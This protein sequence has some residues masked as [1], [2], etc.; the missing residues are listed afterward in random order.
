VLQGEFAEQFGV[1]EGTAFISG[2]A[3]GKPEGILTNSD[4]SSVSSTSNDV[5]H[6]DDFAKLLFALKEPYHANATFLLNR[7]TVRDARILKDTTNQYIWQPGLNGATPATILDKPYL[8]ATDMPTVADAAK[9]VA[10]ATSRRAYWIV[11]RLELA[12][13]RDPFTQAASGNVRFHARKRVGGQV[14]V[15]EAIKYLTIS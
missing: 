4:V 12:I 14:V 7:L 15:P 2:N 11:D 13:L 5:L 10:S 3:V 8:M 9:A 1:A 6:G